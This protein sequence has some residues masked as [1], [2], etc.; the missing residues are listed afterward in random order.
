MTKAIDGKR[1]RHS[2]IEQQ[3]KS[4]SCDV[5]NLDWICDADAYERI[6]SAVGPPFNNKVDQSKLVFDLYS[7]RTKFKTFLALDSDKG[8]KRRKD[9]FSAVA[10]SAARFRKS[11]LDKAGESYVARSIFSSAA[12]LRRLRP[13]SMRSSKQPGSC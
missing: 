11:I 2:V 5:I 3:Q 9:L 6:I 4:E 12:D 13:S 7:A 8:A 1:A 10:E